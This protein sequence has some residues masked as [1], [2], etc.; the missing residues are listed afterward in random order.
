[1]H[2]GR[3]QLGNQREGFSSTTVNKQ[4]WHSEQNKDFP[5]HRATYPQKQT[6][7]RKTK[8]KKERETATRTD[9]EKPKVEQVREAAQHFKRKVSKEERQKNTDKC[10]DAAFILTWI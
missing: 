4:P 8:K 1:M 7:K 5:N 3:F 9:G 10:E 2:A 6:K